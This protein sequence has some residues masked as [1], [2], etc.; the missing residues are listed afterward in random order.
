MNPLIPLLDCNLKVSEFKLQLCYYI[1]FWTNTLGKGMN[2]LILLDC[3]FKV[4]ELKLQLCYYIHFWTNTLGKGMNPL[5]P[6][7]DCNLKVSEFKLQLCYY[8]HFWIN[9]LE[10]GTRN[11]TLSCSPD[12]EL[13]ICFTSGHRYHNLVWSWR[14]SVVDRKNLAEPMSWKEWS[15]GISTIIGYLIP[16]PFYTYILDMI[17]KHIF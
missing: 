8:I 4:S 14:Q 5:I 3:N 7:L 16:N 17:S 13:L 10:K 1:H 2:P 11:P 9:T 12:L 15:N 6:L